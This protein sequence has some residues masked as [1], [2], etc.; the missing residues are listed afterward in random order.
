MKKT[1]E[2]RKKAIWSRWEKKLGM[3]LEE[4]FRK[5]FEQD[6][7]FDEDEEEE[8]EDLDGLISEFFNKLRALE[9]FPSPRT[10][11][12]PPR[13]RYQRPYQKRLHM[14]DFIIGW[15]LTVEMHK[16]RLFGSR[17]RI[18]WKRTCE[19]WNKAYPYDPM[20]P[21]VLKA[22]FYRAITEEKLQQ[23]Y[24]TRKD[25][26]LAARVSEL[27]PYLVKENKKSFERFGEALEKISQLEIA[28]FSEKISRVAYR[29]FERL[30]QLTSTAL[31][32]MDQNNLIL[33]ADTLNGMTNSEQEEPAK[34]LEAELENTK[35]GIESNERPYNKEG[36]EQL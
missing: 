16:Q 23:E 27:L 25:H 26:E 1:L 13:K 19:A 31:G 14:V 15:Q 35:G 36:E 9:Y 30:R 4:D 24:F 34:L 10:P 8:L 29:E 22:T 21:A 11:K 33:L 20:T 32:K 3:P 6:F 17:K 5:K 2:E 18:N 12:N 28:A 7:G